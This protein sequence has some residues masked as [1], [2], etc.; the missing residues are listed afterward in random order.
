MTVYVDDMAAKFGRYTMCHMIAD[1]T[2]ELVNMARRIGV[3]PKWIQKAGTSR[4]HFDIALSKKA[5]AIGY[6]AVQITQ[7]QTAAMCGL[8]RLVGEL[9]KPDNAV[10]DYLNLLELRQRQRATPEFQ[11]VEPQ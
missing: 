11:E 10:R 3:N 6:G 7:R 2:E 8:R 9:G 5:L 1:S 4:E